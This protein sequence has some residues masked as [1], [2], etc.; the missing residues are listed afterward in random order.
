MF[1][2]LFSEIFRLSINKD[3]KVSK[4]LSNSLHDNSWTIKFSHDL[5]DWVMDLLDNLMSLLEEVCLSNSFPNLRVWI[6]ESS[7]KFSS[8]SFFMSLTNPNHNFMSF[9]SKK[10]WE[11]LVPHWVKAFVWTM[12]LNR[13]ST[14]DL[15][16]RRR[17]FM[18]ISPN[19]Y[20][21]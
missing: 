13:I 8:K 10:I 1:L 5:Y 19:W 11:S 18:Q 17:P 3:A 14:M 4:I 16:Q 20:V 12:A 7:R 21:I 2:F 9:P 6:L 15:L